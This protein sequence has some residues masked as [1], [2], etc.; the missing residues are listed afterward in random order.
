M[1]VSARALEKV[2]RAD[3][4]T[5]G[6]I[7]YIIFTFLRALSFVVVQMLY[8]REPDLRPFQLLFMRSVFGIAIL[9]VQMNVSLK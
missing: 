7:Y 2:K 3:K 6:I 9:L 8:N 5:L 4:P 1:A